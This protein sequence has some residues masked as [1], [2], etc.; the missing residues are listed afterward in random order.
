MD[1]P[2][3]RPQLDFLTALTSA[4]T[5]LLSTH[6]MASA[7]NWFIIYH[8]QQLDYYTRFDFF[9]NWILNQTCGL[10]N[11][12]AFIPDLASLMAID[13]YTRLGFGCNRIFT[14]ALNSAT[15]RLLNWSRNLQ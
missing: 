14:A 9:I 15:A 2:W 12:W 5:G 13:F 11:N 8:L 4:T 10:F 7:P 3:L 6:C 1:Q